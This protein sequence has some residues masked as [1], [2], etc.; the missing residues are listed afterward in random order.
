MMPATFRKATFNRESEAVRLRQIM[1][2]AG[3]YLAGT[4]GRPRLPPAE[5]PLN[6]RLP[7]ENNDERN[8]PCRVVDL[9]SGSGLIGMLIRKAGGEVTIVDASSSRVSAEARPFFHQADAVTYSLEP[10]DLIVCAGLLYHLNLSSQITLAANMAGKPVILDTHFAR[11]A[12]VIRGE[13]SGQFRRPTKSTKT[14]RPF[15][16]TIE[17]LRKLFPQHDLTEPF[18]RLSADRKVM[19]LRPKSN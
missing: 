18:P 3:E 11:R 6:P 19:V 17:S 13:F 9:G 16:H 8:T 14:N 15:V 2:A 1:A 12:D 4:A 10:F 5:S 7:P